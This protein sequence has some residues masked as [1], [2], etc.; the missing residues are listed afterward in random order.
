MA[1]TELRGASPEFAQVVGKLV[2]GILLGCELVCSQH[3]PMDVS[4]AL[5]AEMPG[6]MHE[7]FKQPDDAIILKADRH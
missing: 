5:A 4:G 6:A 2:A 7:D 3:G 1:S